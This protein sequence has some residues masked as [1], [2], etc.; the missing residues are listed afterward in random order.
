[1]KTTAI[2]FDYNHFVESEQQDA[3]S[4]VKPIFDHSPITKAINER[5]SFSDQL[6]ERQRKLI[7]R[8]QR[9]ALLCSLTMLCWTI[10]R[11]AWFLFIFYPN[12]INP[13][14]MLLAKNCTAIALMVDAVCLLL[15]FK[16]ATP[17]YNLFCRNC[18]SLC[19]FCC[20]FCAA[21]YADRHEI[22]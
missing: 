2:V 16:F 21:C 18:D 3:R 7:D 12:E 15:T 22:N 5:A 20:A 10:E 9:N 14:L 17:L 19:H 4:L 8:V 6:N 11:L 1:M 13:N